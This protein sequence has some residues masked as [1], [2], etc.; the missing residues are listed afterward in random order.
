[1]AFIQIKDRY[2]YDSIINTDQI[3]Q[4]SKWSESPNAWAKS[5]DKKGYYRLQFSN[6]ENVEID[7]TNTAIIEKLSQAIGYSL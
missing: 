7:I 4:I 1:M 5:S 3:N 2:G 6:G